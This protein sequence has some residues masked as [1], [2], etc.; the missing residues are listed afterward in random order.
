M[1]P[2]PPRLREPILNLPA[3]ISVCLAVLI[4]IHAFRMFLSDETDFTLIIDWA[5]GPRALGR[6]LRGRSGR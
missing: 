3:A 5:V 6:G 4:G 1:S 2:Q